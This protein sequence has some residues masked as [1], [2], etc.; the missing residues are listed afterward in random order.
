LSKKGQRHEEAANANTK[1][2]HDARAKTHLAQWLPGRARRGEAAYARR[3][4][5]DKAGDQAQQAAAEE[6]VAHAE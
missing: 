2:Y 3:D 4:G 5:A 1:K 6:E